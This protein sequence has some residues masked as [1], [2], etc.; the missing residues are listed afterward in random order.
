[1]SNSHRTNNFSDLWNSSFN[2]L[3]GTTN[4]NFW[5]FFREIRLD[6]CGNIDFIRDKNLI[7]LTITNY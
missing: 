6:E 5:T 7:L 3:V 1:M 2:K 4:T